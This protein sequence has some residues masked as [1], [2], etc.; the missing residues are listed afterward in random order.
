MS[1]RVSGYDIGGRGQGFR[2]TTSKAGLKAL[3]E[4]KPRTASVSANVRNEHLSN[5]RKKSYRPSNMHG[6]SK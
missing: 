5:T 2:G 1:C 3:K 4:V 6:F